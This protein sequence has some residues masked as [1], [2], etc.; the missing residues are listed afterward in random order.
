MTIFQDGRFE[1]FILKKG[2]QT[3]FECVQE[4]QIFTSCCFHFVRT[5]GILTDLFNTKI[6]IESLFSA[7]EKNKKH[8]IIGVQWAW[9]TNESALYLK[10]IQEQSACVK[11]SSNVSCNFAFRHHTNDI[12]GHTDTRTHKQTDF[13][14]FGKSLARAHVVS[15]A[16][17]RIMKSVGLHSCRFHTKHFAAAIVC[18]YFGFFFSSFPPLHFLDITLA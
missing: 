1:D 5:G 10:R 4:C 11:Y 17:E 7:N 12:C 9:Q 18:I 2:N 6:T 3:L 16:V 14:N 8:T 13:L 15:S